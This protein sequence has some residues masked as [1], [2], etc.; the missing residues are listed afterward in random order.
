VRRLLSAAGGVWALNL[1]IVL[2]CAAVLAGPIH[3][4][5]DFNV[6]EGMLGAK[7]PSLPGDRWGRRA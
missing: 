5:P 4:Q 3:E 2:G 1:A 6:S 7:A